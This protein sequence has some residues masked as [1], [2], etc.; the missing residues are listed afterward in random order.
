VHDFKMSG[1]ANDPLSDDAAWMRQALEQG[2][3]GVG[4]TSPNP[5]VGAVIVAEGRLI[6]AGYH[7]KAGLPHAEVEAIADAQARHPALLSAASIYVTLEPCS[8][9]GR[10]GPCTEAI[11]AAGIRRVVWGADDPNPAHAGSAQKV[12]AAAGIE[13]TTRVLEAEC[14][15]LIRPF[16][17]WITTGMPY[18]IAKA[19]QSLD[20]RITRPAGEGRW[21]TSETA[22]EHG[23][24]LRARVDAILVGAET[25][26]QDDPQLTLRGGP[27]EKTQPLR[28][29]LTRTGNLP[30]QARVFTDEFKERT[31]VLRG[32]TLSEALRH[33]GRRG[34]VSVL[35]EGG[36]NVLAQAFREQVVDEVYW[37]IAPRLCG[38]GVPAI[39]DAWGHSIPL[40]GVEVI[41]IG[42][43]V[44]VHGRPAWPNQISN[45]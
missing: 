39:A 24:A 37:Y 32:M 1:S 19:G 25:V 18:V 31:L 16:A 2:R 34:I 9:H 29:V 4:L 5:P 23:R 6:G 44:C 42:D 40:E 30:P 41:P 28:V 11:Q 14:L 10:T 45:P 7:H 43:N 38:M 33:L 12:L 17:K 21:I 13:V 15:A 3:R 36:G 22:R 26:R 8:T 20:G 27:P 35:I